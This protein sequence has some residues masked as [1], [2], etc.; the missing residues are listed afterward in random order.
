MDLIIVRH[1]RPERVENDDSDGPADPPLSQLGI[2]QAR[3]VADFL[4]G[5]K[6][7]RIVS[8]SMRRALETAEPLSKTTRITVS[9]RDDLRESDHN[10]STYIPVEEDYDAFRDRV[11]GAFDDLIA[12]HR[13]ETVVVFCHG[14]VTSVYLQ[15]LWSLDN[16]FM[17][18]PDYT[19]IT[20]VQASTNGLRT[21]RS[22]NETSHVRDLIERPT[23]G[24]KI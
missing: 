23:F 7:D 15:T 22:I 5:E 1:A 20:R 11:V 3:A 14:M 8:S 4:K 6:I 13:G 12:T 24:K 18:Q 2:K 10:S 17:I 21:V 19:G 9:S 16:P